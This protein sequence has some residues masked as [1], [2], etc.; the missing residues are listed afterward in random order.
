M[1]EDAVI[2][3]ELEAAELTEEQKRAQRRGLAQLAISLAMQGRWNDALTINNRI[4]EMFPDDPEAFNRIANAYSQLNRVND[5]IEAYQ[6]AL[7]SQPTNAIAQRNLTRLQRLVEAGESSSGSNQKLPP[8]FFVE[9]V[10]KT[11]LT[12]LVDVDPDVALRVTAGDEV[13]L[14]Q[15][16]DQVSVALVEGPNLGRLEPTLAERLKRL[17]KTGNKYQAGVVMAEPGRM[18]LLIRETDQ[19][20]ANEGKIS[21]PPRTVAVRAYTREGLLRR[22]DDDEFDSEASDIESEEID[23][24]EENPAEFGFSETSGNADSDID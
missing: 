10:G 5:A 7:E 24:D 11:G 9:E 22:A 23:D 13:V 6:K 1:T 2:E 15:K 17:M 3:E 8:A 20:P 21:F 16:K 4:L 19:S 12:T 18:R 14:Q